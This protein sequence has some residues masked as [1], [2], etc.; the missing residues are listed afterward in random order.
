V[1]INVAKLEF[2]EVTPIFPKI[3]VSDAKNAAANAK[4]RQS[5]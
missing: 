4:N 3:A 5:K 2:I 1:R